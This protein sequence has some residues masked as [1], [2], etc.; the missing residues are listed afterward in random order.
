MGSIPI[1]IRPRSA[2]TVAFGN[3]GPI[4]SRR[5][6]F[7]FCWVEVLGMKLKLPRL[8]LC[9]DSV[10]HVM[11]VLLLGL[12]VLAVWNR[13]TIHNNTKRIDSLIDDN[14]SEI[15]SLKERLHAVDGK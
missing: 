4:P 9:L 7:T 15:V 2:V 13:S 12:L 11:F 6:R 5:L 14:K 3:L 10:L 8:P 1:V